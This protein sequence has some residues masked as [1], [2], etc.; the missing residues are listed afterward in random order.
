MVLRA[1]A[2]TRSF[3]ERPSTSE[4]TVTLSR[5]GRNRRLVLRFE[6][7]TL[8]PTCAAL[9]VS[10]HRRDMAKS[11][12]T[13]RGLDD[14]EPRRSLAGTPRQV[15]AMAPPLRRVRSGDRGRIVVEGRER[16]GKDSSGSK[17]A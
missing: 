2:E 8:C 3:T 5:L 13:I 7:L 1:F 16:Q 9:P 6:W 14:Q 15:A 17:M 11:F 10:S 4:I 12:F